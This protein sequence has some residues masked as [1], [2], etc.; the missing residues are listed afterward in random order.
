MRDTATRNRHHQR[1]RQRTR[2][3][4][5]NRAMA[6][7]TRTNAGSE[8]GWQMANPNDD[9]YEYATLAS[10]RTDKHGH[11]WHNRTPV[12]MLREET[13]VA[14]MNRSAETDAYLQGMNDAARRFA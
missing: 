12:M 14:T 6:V 1:V 11:T 7:P 4:S 5:A 8:S 9:P 10:T 3:Q 2:T 13:E